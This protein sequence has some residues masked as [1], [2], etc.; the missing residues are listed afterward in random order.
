MTA[1]AARR[2]AA[3]AGIFDTFCFFI[4]ITPRWFVFLAYQHSKRI[5]KLKH[6]DLFV[7]GIVG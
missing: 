3:S 7:L 5:A 6:A 2:A 1:G 4:K